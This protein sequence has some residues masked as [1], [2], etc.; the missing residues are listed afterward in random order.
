MIYDNL[1]KKVARVKN[2]R[3]VSVSFINGPRVE[4]IDHNPDNEYLVKFIDNKTEK[5]YYEATLK[6]GYWAAS[7]IEYFVEWRI[8]LYDKNGKKVFE[9]LFNPTGKKI[10]INFDSKA[11]GDTIAWIP[12]VEEFRKKYECEIVVSTF[13]NILFETQYPNLKFV[14]PGSIVNNIYTQYNIGWFNNENKNPKDPYIIPLQQTAT[15]ILGLHFTEIKPNISHPSNKPNIKE[16][17]VTLSVQSTAQA[18]YWNYKGGWQQV[19]NYLNSKGYKV[20][21]VDKHFSFGAGNCINTIPKNVIDKT[22]CGFDEA[23]SLIANADFHLGIS[24]GLSWLSWALG[25]HTVMVSSFSKP[26]CEFTTNITRVYNDTPYSGFFNTVEH[27]LDPSNWNWNPFKEMSTLEDW[28]KFETIT[29]EQ[30]INKIDE[31]LEIL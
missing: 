10:Y 22:G 5:N 12:Y 24:S 3:Q 25:T 28:H 11:L 15:D 13:H 14:K 30:V 9:Q 2:N 17:Y 18:K 4:I 23:I 8:E 19:I 7:S 20:I 29:P 21:C 26:L 31:Y 27:K 6:G 1:I 16:K